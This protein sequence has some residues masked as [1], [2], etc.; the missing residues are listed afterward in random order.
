MKTRIIVLLGAA[1]VLAGVA[2]SWSQTTPSPAASPAA[3]TSTDSRDG[4][5]QSVKLSMASWRAKLA[6]LGARASNGTTAAGKDAETDISGAWAR[7]ELAAERLDSVGVAGWA[8]AKAAYER[9]VDDMN[10]AWAKFKPAKT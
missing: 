3:A 8:D 1:L 5:L 9:A 4:Y 10:A 2:P 6:D 7:V